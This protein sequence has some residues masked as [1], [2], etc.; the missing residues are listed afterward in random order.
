MQPS[1]E[2]DLLQATRNII[3]IPSTA[4]NPEAL[5]EALDFI[6]TMIWAKCPDA[7]IERFEK[8]G[9]PSLLAY[10]DSQRPEN[11]RII[12]N[13]HLDVVPGKPEQYKAI[14]KDGKLYGRGAYDMKAACVILTDVFCDFV[15]KVPYQLG[16]QIV[17]DEENAGQ[18][19]TL[20]Q[21]EQGVRA[22]FVICG[23]CGRSTGVHEIANEAKGM[24]LA[25]IGFRGTTAH[26]AYPWRGDN[27]AAKAV[28]FV[29]AVHARYPIPK[30]ESDAT[31]M[32]ITSMS[33][34]GE[35]PTKIPDSATVRID[36]RYVAGDPIFRSKQHF[37]ALIEELDPH[38]EIINLHDFSSPLYTSPRN[39][40]LLALK[41]SAERVEGSTFSLV[42]RHATSDGRHFGDV[43]NEACE[44]GIA[45]E[46]QHGDGEYITLEAFHNYL[47]TMRD[48]LEKTITAEQK[49]RHLETFT[50]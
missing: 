37:A 9:K 31:T 14:I 32:T 10:R 41:A 24:V 38:A 49:H 7:T 6:A 50:S 44:F 35:A 4:Q 43:G 27:A 12:L 21:I 13:G 39:P 46:H 17:T 29:Q 16:L 1:S 5:Q 2:E 23:E 30:E 8:G 26:G 20:H 3:A 25:E 28:A 33:A 40:L 42:R 22:D 34:H 11:F 47:A 48:F 36:A 15:D 18:D 19:G 45:G